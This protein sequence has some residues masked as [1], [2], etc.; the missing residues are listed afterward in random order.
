MLL[1]LEVPMAQAPHARPALHGPSCTPLRSASPERLVGAF[2][3]LADIDEQALG[4]RAGG[5]YQGVARAKG[6]GPGVN[7]FSRQLDG[8]QA[9]ACQR[10]L[11]RPNGCCFGRQIDQEYF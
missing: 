5:E 8:Q 11:Q 10:V 4:Q 1:D 6:V 7:E 3:V 9:S 2:E